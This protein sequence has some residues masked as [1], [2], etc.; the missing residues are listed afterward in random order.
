[1]E[2]V[3]RMNLP[4]YVAFD[5][6]SGGLLEE[7]SLLS[8]HFSVL[9]K[10]LNEIASLDLKTKPDNGNYILTAGGLEVNKIN[11][12][13]HDK[14]A[15]TCKEA[16]TLIWKFLNF[17]SFGGQIKLIPV[18]HNVAHDIKLINAQ[19]IGRK[20][21]EAFVRYHVLDTATLALAC[22][23]IGKLP[24]DM[25]ISLGVLAKHFN[26]PEFEA[27]TAKGD[28]QAT[29]FVAKNLISIL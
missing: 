7:H 17:H 19:T 16:A 8:A 5:T 14:V 21:W 26:A 3:T 28:T 11:L 20:A 24:A 2:E 12:V 13:E 6:E 4:M 15:V 9:D 18:G 27:H 29:V 1:M 22:Q 10:D 25:S 23:V